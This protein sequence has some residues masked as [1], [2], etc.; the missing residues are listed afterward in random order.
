[1]TDLLSLQSIVLLTPVR[2]G[3]QAGQ[4]NSVE[5]LLRVQAADPPEG[6]ARQRAPKALEAMTT[7]VRRSCGGGWSRERGA[8]SD[9]DRPVIGS[10][11]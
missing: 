9:G 7:G 5:V 11:R 10:K 6:L 3:L 8:S 2:A 4:D 1:M